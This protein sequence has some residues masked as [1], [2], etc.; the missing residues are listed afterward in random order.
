MGRYLLIRLCSQ[1]LC[2]SM[3]W[4]CIIGYYYIAVL[5]VFVLAHNCSALAEWEIIAAGAIR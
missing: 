2:V 1:R 4:G 5:Y 3:N